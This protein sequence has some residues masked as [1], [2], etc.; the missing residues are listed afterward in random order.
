MIESYIS[1]ALYLATFAIGIYI[2]KMHKSGNRRIYMVWLFIFLC[3]GYMCG[4][5]W[6]SYE[7]QYYDVSGEDWRYQTEPF[8]LFCFK[9]MHYVIPDFWLFCG[10]CKCFYLY[11]LYKLIK[12]VTPNYTTVLALLMPI[13][14]CFMLIS[15]PFRYMMGLIPINYAIGMII[16]AIESNRRSFSIYLKVVPLVI[17]ALCFHNTCAIFLVLFPLLIFVK[18]LAKTNRCVLMGSF[19]IVIFLMS[20]VSFINAQKEAI[21]Q[22][23]TLMYS[24]KDYSSWYES[25]D[26]SSLFSIGN[27]IQIFLF[28]IVLISRDSVVGKFKHSESVYTFT[29]L[30][31]FLDRAFL[32]IPTAFRFAIPFGYFFAIYM[33]MTIYANRKIAAIFLL[34]FSLQFTKS[35]W[36]SFDWIPYS[37]SI[38]YIIAGH[39]PFNER[40]TYNFDKY[41]ERTGEQFD[42]DTH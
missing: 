7:T 25:S 6:R 14:L 19:I 13:S 21:N 38:P 26:N 20:D 41:T 16:D 8:S 2:D 22:Y 9:Y 23:F 31:F 10:V 1:I 42:L 18:S 32:L 17:V 12:K 4:G 28:V 24:V 15:N 11:S 34:Y 39:L 3:F 5:D 35:M 29:I 36:T 27:M 40:S 37:N 30:Y 33:M